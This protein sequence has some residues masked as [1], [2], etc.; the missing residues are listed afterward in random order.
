ML[1]NVVVHQEKTLSVV[2]NM[3][4]TNIDIDSKS[5]NIILTLP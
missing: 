5:N 2:I 3:T 4:K 1:F